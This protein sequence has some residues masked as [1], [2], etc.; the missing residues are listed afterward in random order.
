MVILHINND[1]CYLTTQDQN[2]KR[3]LS[4]SLKFRQK[5]Y[6]HTN[7]YK[8]RLWDGYVRYFDAKTGR[9]LTGL[10]PEV[11]LALN[12]LNVK[13]DLQDHRA[14]F[15]FAIKEINKDFLN[16]WLPKGKKPITLEDYQVELVNKAI[17]YHRGLIK[18]PTASGKTFIMLSILKSI[19]TGMPILF[20]A[21]RKS[22]VRQNYKEMIS[23]GFKNVGRFDGNIHQPNV[24]TCATI[25]SIYACISPAK[26]T[27]C[28][29]DHKALS[30]KLDSHKYTSD[31]DKKKD[32]S[33]LKKL[34]ERL[35]WSQLMPVLLT[36]FRVLMVDEVHMA[37]SS[38]AINIYKKLTGCSVRF[39][40]SAT[41]FK[42][43]H[44]QKGTN[45][46]IDGDPV[47]KYAVK[48]YFGGV[49]KRDEGELT[50]S[51][52]QERG[53]LAKSQCIFYPITEPQIPFDIYIDA[54][55]NGIAQ[56][57][58]F[59]QIVARLAKARKGRTLILVER[60]AHG[61]T[62]QQLLPGCLWVQGKDNDET[63]DY[64]IER[65][66]SA[67]GDVIA[68]ATSGIFSA[69]INVFIHNFINCSSGKAAHEII[70][71]MGRGLRPAN[72]KDIL[73]Y[74]DFLFKINPYLEE[75]ALKRIRI[76]EEEG[77]K[78]II[79]SDLTDLD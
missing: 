76:L 8:Q 32:K 67:K 54:V 43:E 62:L 37:G 65:L 3:K 63:R 56:N 47:Q 30:L 14:R 25:Q 9:F 78:V 68:I 45:K 42:F 2:L 57:W 5:N 7:L 24:I 38:T 70:Q 71:R 51:F 27:Q 34:E 17:K 13:Y 26:I 28:K 52:L 41:P 44:K 72:D 31:K 19:P 1:F 16:Q 21:S 53:R 29:K 23:W 66:Q 10:L 20:L 59:H 50:T 58:D 48:G 73:N 15:E 46:I 77:H 64:V 4:D 35:K 11:L 75:H 6:F 60:L 22:I 61:D 39:G 33:K 40:V 55:T 12:H 79:K 74:Y 36:K 18:A 49:I 69:G